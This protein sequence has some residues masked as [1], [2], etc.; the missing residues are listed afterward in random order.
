MN[1]ILIK[2]SRLVTEEGL[3]SADLLISSGKIKKIAPQIESK[4]DVREINAEGMY[5]MP[6][7]IDPH[8]H[9]ELKAYNSVSSDDFYSGSC[10]AAAGGVT[11]FI[12]FA[13]PEAG[14]GI[15][16]C[17]N[18]KSLSADSKSIIDY[19]F[20]AQI[21]EWNE[22]KYSEMEEAVDTGVTS[23]KIFMPA[24]EGWGMQD[25]GLYEALLSSVK[26]KSLIM[27]HAE[28]EKLAQGFTDK[29][30]KAEKDSPAYYPSSRPNIVEREAI[31]R[32]CLLAD[33]AKAPLYICHLSTAE[34]MDDL[35]ELRRKGHSVYVESCPQYLMLTG[36]ILKKKDGYLYVCCPPLRT[37]EDTYELW[38][39]VIEDVIDV[40]GTDHCPFTRLYKSAI[41]DNFLKIPKGLPGTENSLSLMFTNGVIKRKMEI[42]KLY[43]KMSLNPAK[44][45]G[46]Y[47]RK[48]TLKEGADADI[49]IFNPQDPKIIKSEELYTNCDWSPYEGM[50]IAGS[51]DYT[52]SRGEIVYEKGEISARQGRGQFLKRKSS[53]YYL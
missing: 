49:V 34:G 11:T 41:G 30:V 33:E 16:D 12:D 31:A 5:T 23:F 50:E 14:Q 7:I 19:S 20:H 32:A 51:P 9:F 53:S 52:I 46:L 21:T 48:G 17:I 3:I 18:E 22:D 44:I 2:G 6:G 8:V 28:N 27:V 15:G 13:I 35:R 43:E 45:F 36:E 4:G 47:P 40:I 37:K 25:D 26:L 29:L 42:T 38:R 24:T 39:G 10:A 1:K